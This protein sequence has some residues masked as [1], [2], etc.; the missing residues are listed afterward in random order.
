[1][2]SPSLCW[3]EGPSYLHTNIYALPNAENNTSLYQYWPRT[4]DQQQKDTLLTKK[5]RPTI[6][7]FS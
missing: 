7:L 4:A 3:T 2:F 6:A 1:M 5:A